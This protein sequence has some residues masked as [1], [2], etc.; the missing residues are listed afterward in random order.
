[1][2]VYCQIN[3]FF[4]FL[5]KNP[6]VAPGVIILS[7][8]K[9][10]PGNSR[11]YLRRWKSHSKPVSESSHSSPSLQDSPKVTLMTLL[12]KWLAVGVGLRSQVKN[13]NWKWNG[14]IKKKDATK[15][16]NPMWKGKKEKKKKKGKKRTQAQ[17]FAI[18]FV[19]LS[20]GWCGLDE[21]GARSAWLGKGDEVWRGSVGVVRQRGW[22][23]KR[24]AW[25]GNGEEFL[26][27]GVLV[28]RKKLLVGT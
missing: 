4:I 20:C 9:V 12:L 11:S 13:R 18:V 23:V 17:N 26:W 28:W 10:A 16:R 21:V 14:K 2:W 6:K 15:P 27:V 22:S 1:M 8:M 3:V 24:Y 25:F 5:F 7:L 19:S